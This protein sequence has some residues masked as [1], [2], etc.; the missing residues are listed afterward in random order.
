MLCDAGWLRR[1]DEVERLT[2]NWRYQNAQTYITEYN[3]KNYTNDPVLPY[4][5]AR[6]IIGQ[7]VPKGPQKIG[8]CVSWGWGNA[9]NYTAILQIAGKLS[10]MG[11]LNL[12]KGGKWDH[13]APDHPN[14]RESVTLIEEYQ[15]CCTEVIYA[16]SRVE[17]GG[18]RGSRE[19]GSVGVW[20]SDAVTKYGTLSRKRLGP[21]DP[22]RAK[23]WGANGLPDNLEADAKKH[24]FR[25]S[26]PVT[27]YNDALPLL[28][29]WRVIPVCS[30]RGFTM[31][32][33]SKG[34][35]RPSGTWMHCMLFCAVDN[36]G[37]VLCSQSWGDNVPDGPRYLDQPDNTFWVDP[38]T[39]D[40]MLRQKDSYSPAGFLGYSV[41]D[42]ISWKH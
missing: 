12:L 29:N 7:D 31:T 38:D 8:D 3:L 11:T 13:D 41:E 14:Y 23:D 32:R 21:Y 10:R 42:F 17:V 34:R 22:Q 5:I 20:A 18:Q 6:Q 35:C 25:E 2:K 1:P 37:F 16:L 40:K 36:E 19:D 9:V 4:T 26:T 15:E 28:K 24:V 33:D 30:D 27:N 39:V